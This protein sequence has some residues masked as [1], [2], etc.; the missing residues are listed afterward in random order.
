MSISLMEPNRVKSGQE[1][2]V[3]K[4]AAATRFSPPPKPAPTRGEITRTKILDAAEELFAANGYHGV[5]L[6]DITS[7]A[8]V[9]LA[10][11][12][13]HFKTKELLFKAVIQRRAPEHCVQMEQA[14]ADARAA[15]APDLPSNAALVAAYASAALE[16]IE[17]DKGWACYQKI[18]VNMQNQSF[19]D[20]SAQIAN[21]EFDNII[22]EYIDAFRLTNPGLD[23]NRIFYAVFFL[24]GALI[25]LLSQ[26]S[27]IEQYFD[28][29]H[30]LSDH[31]EVVERLSTFFEAALLNWSGAAAQ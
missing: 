23:E 11:A 27:G 7:L 19:D 29:R 14:L 10:L 28:H 4:Q 25:H 24:H 21:V 12:S 3:A 2:I 17:R 13:Y 20:V 18:V 9:E 30:S 1:T 6:R 26:S 5:S 15:A 31:R 22:R 16:A 8:Q